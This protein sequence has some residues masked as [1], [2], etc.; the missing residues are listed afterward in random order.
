MMKIDW[1]AKLTS[2]KFW[3]A[4]IGFVTAVLTAFN[5]NELTIEQVTAIISATSILIAYI[6]G[7]GIVDSAR[8]K[9]SETLN[10]IVVAIDGNKLKNTISEVV[11]SVVN[12]TTNST[13]KINFDSNEFY[14]AFNAVKMKDVKEDE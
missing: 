8:A 14:K 5:V 12:D 9:N 7:E 3:C 10:D 4:V 13:V 11:Q 1:R 2:R 6:I